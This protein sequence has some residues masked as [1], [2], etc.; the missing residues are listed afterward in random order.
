MEKNK[1]RFDENVE[2]INFTR[3]LGACVVPSEGTVAMSLGDEVGRTME[4][5]G[6]AQEKRDEKNDLSDSY[7]TPNQRAC[8]LKQ[9]MGQDVYESQY[10]DSRVELMAVKKRRRETAMSED[11]L[12]CLIET[13][14]EAIIQGLMDEQ[15]VRELLMEDDDQSPEI[16]SPA[17]RRKPR[18]EKPKSPDNRQ[19]DSKSPSRSSPSPKRDVVMDNVEETCTKMEVNDTVS[20]RKAK[21]RVRN[22]SNNIKSKREREDID[23]PKRVE[24]ATKLISNNLFTLSI[25]DPDSNEDAPSEQKAK[26]KIRRVASNRKPALPEAEKDEPMSSPRKR[27]SVKPDTEPMSPENAKRKRKT[28]KSDDESLS[29][30]QEA[31]KP[32]AETKK[33]RESE[34]AEPSPKRKRGEEKEPSSPATG[35]GEKKPRVK[36]RKSAGLEEGIRLG[37]VPRA[38]KKKEDPSSS[39][40]PPK[41]SAEEK[42]KGWITE[43]LR[44]I[45]T[46]FFGGGEA[47]DAIIETIDERDD[48]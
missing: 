16:E 2:V 3:T 35:E 11:D 21:K 25:L 23:E 24:S 36:R 17:K 19:E 27:S 42:R 38:A 33:K 8:L 22:V 6:A 46:L 4:K 32:E 26:R 13:P 30:K 44:N 31:M 39:D 48:S 41:K 43:K 5:L 34:P 40:G 9:D 20:E 10:P 29:S 1:I 18:T 15:E 14:S 45:P 47:K 7:K 28:D 37:S 12:R